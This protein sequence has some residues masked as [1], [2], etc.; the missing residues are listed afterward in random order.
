MSENT[1]APTE[2]KQP[3]NVGYLAA[4]TTAWVALAFCLAVVGF[5]V[6]NAIRARS[7]QPVAPAEIELLRAQ[8]SADRDNDELRA[9]IRELDVEL[10]TGYFTAR[11][12]AI[13]GTYL[14]AIGV[15]V[16][17]LAAHL[18][19][20]FRAQAPMPD[21]QAAGRSWVDAALSLRS[22]T[23]LALVM[24]G[25]LLAMVILARHDA[26][27]EYIRAAE[28]MP[29]GTD[30]EVAAAPDIPP[31][32]VPLATGGATP[33][34]Q[35]GVPPPPPAGPVRRPG[36]GTPV[37][38]PPGPSAS[39]P[40]PQPAAPG[41]VPHEDQSGSRPEPGA[42]KPDGGSGTKPAA[43]DLPKGWP[44]FRGPVAGRVEATG[45][46]VEWGAATGQGIVWKTEVPLPGHN[47][48][49]FC[50]GRVFLTGADETRREIYCFDATAGKA[51]WAQ[52]FN[53]LPGTGPDPPK[54]AEGTGYAASTMTTDGERVFAIFPNGD[55]AAYDLEG[56]L[57][58]SVPLG[59][60]ENA[61]GHAS[62]LAVY[63]D[64]LII[65]LDQGMDAEDGLSALIALDAATGKQTWRTERPV[66]NSWTSPIV[67]PSG[68]GMQVVTSAD[69]WVISYDPAT[70]KELWRA[71]CLMGDVGPS[72]CYAN[73]LVFACSD[74]AGLFAIR[75]AATS[76]GAAGDIV[77]SADEGLPDTA[78]PATDG[79]LVFL[80]ASYGTVTCYDAGQGAKVWE[81]D[82]E[83]VFESSPVIVGNRVYLSDGD[84]VT[85]IFEAARQYK[86]VGQGKIGEPITATPAFVD[87]RIYLR[88]ETHLYCVGAPEA[89]P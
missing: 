1:S 69:P 30:G 26:S 16:F 40:A 81:Q 25:F 60:P 80:A 18:A 59:M 67:V 71:E 64:R 10:R 86:A 63:R 65:Q 27:S 5:L 52:P 4:S 48:P 42:P 61:Y 12:R 31:G 74:L 9:R 84:G 76:E 14:L 19:A 58:W 54:V 28:E 15:V 49:I 7:H 51:V 66:R 6:A 44:M 34:N 22:L 38:P 8:L 53:V 77:W 33:A 87:G 72:P 89:K 13:Q 35:P 20:K 36:S 62:S 39:R 24:A 47:S 17:F 45:F 41:R 50:E 46:P 29:K 88:G 78:S 37:P 21:A 32:P 83:S 56:K 79:Q 73:G 43:G 82:L 57:Q 85:H 68:D 75:A 3:D 11:A 55:V 23:A 2:P 70:G